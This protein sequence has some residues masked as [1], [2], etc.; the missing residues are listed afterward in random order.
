MVAGLTRYNNQATI[1]NV[2][3]QVSIGLHKYCPDNRSLIVV[4][5]GDPVDDFR[6]KAR[7]F[8]SSPLQEIIV[9]MYRG[10]SGKGS[11]E[12]KIEIQAMFF[13]DEKPYLLERWEFADEAI[14]NVGTCRKSS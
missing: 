10:V 1:G 9:L 14:A 6:D 12:G 3:K 11:A 8:Q 4:P 7:A 2:V 5:D 13:E